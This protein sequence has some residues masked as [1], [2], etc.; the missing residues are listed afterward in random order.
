[1]KDNRSGDESRHLKEQCEGRTE[2]THIEYIWID[3]ICIDQS[4]VLERNH[5]VALMSKI[6]SRCQSVIMWL[7]DKDGVCLRAA[8]A[9]EKNLSY[10]SLAIVLCNEY[11]RRLWVVQEII[12]APRIYVRVRGGQGLKWPAMQG[13]LAHMPDWCLERIRSTRSSA[14]PLVGYGTKL[15]KPHRSLLWCIDNFCECEC[16]DP[17]DKVFGLVRL[18]TDRMKDGGGITIDYQRSVLEVF[19][20]VVIRMHAT[21]WMWEQFLYGD[22]EKAATLLKLERSMGLG[23][24]VIRRIRS[25]LKRGC[26]RKS[27]QLD[28]SCLLA[29][30][31]VDT[32]WTKGIRFY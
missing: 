15:E 24:K 21:R 3:Q 32:S 17:R 2:L 29:S 4:N 10:W 30:L 5:Q 22:P 25:F 26:R 18:I 31:K 13:A 11:F 20:D 14:I 23:D 28:V 1:M 8:Q 12:L 9:F 27:D 16:Q 7:N 6:Y 19:V